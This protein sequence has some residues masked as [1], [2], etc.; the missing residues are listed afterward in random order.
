MISASGEPL[1]VVTKSEILRVTED[2]RDGW[3]QKKRMLKISLVGKGYKQN[4]RSQNLGIAKKG[5]GRTPA[6]ICLVD[7]TY[8]VYRGQPK[9][10]IDPQTRKQF[11]RK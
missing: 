9:V 11:P 5:G 7:L 2:F 1:L 4:R 8:V 10:I 3:L 6:K